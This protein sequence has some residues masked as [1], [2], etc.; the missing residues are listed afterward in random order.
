MNVYCLVFVYFVRF[1]LFCFNCLFGYLL[2][3]LLTNIFSRRFIGR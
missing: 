3:N 1:I 2:I